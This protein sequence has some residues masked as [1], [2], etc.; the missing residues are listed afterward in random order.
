MSSYMEAEAW[1]CERT[2]SCSVDLDPTSIDC[3]RPGLPCSCFSDF[4]CCCWFLSVIATGTSIFGLASSVAAAA[5]TDEE[6]RTWIEGKTLTRSDDVVAAE[7]SFAVFIRSSLEEGAWSRSVL[8]GL[9]RSSCSSA[10]VRRLDVV[11]YRFMVDYEV[12]LPCV[13]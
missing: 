13:E 10:G 9:L 8:P 6:S 3:R 4:R 11:M 2:S 12:L 1:I 5:M 7:P